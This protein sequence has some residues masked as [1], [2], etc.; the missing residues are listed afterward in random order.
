M[1]TMR[2]QDN[3]CKAPP[4]TQVIF[5]VQK[6]FSYSRVWFKGLFATGLASRQTTSYLSKGS[7]S[8]LFNNHPSSTRLKNALKPTSGEGLFAQTSRFPACVKNAVKYPAIGLPS[9]IFHVFSCWVRSLSRLS[10][11]SCGVQRGR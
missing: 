7:A 6:A 10:A 9:S 1:F 3:R 11:F 2:R 4:N 5:Q 8:G